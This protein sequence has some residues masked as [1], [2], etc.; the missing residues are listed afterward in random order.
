MRV[1]QD[2]SIYPFKGLSQSEVLS[3]LE[4]DSTFMFYTNVRL[5]ERES[6]NKK[7]LYFDRDNGFN[8]G[9]ENRSHEA[10]KV[11]TIGNL[12]KGIWYKFSNLGSGGVQYI[13]VY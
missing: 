8:W 13:F 3:K 5:K 10:E 12:Q 4:D 11:K 7:K 1:K 9:K 6:Y 2:S